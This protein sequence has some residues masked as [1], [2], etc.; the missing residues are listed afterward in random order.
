MSSPFPRSGAPID[1]FMTM[2]DKKMDN[3]SG[4]LLMEALLAISAAVIVL[5]LGAQL[6]YVSLRSSQVAGDRNIGLGLVEEGIGAVGNIATE[7][8]QNIYALTKTGTHY[9]PVV[10]TGKWTIVLGDQSVTVGTK[11]FTRY[12]TVSNVCRDTVTRNI[13]GSTDTNGSTML[14]VT[15]GGAFD[16]ST[17]L[18][19]MNV[20][21][22]DSGDMLSTGEYMLRWRNKTCA[23]TSW[24]GGAGSGVKSCPD[25][26]Y[27]SKTNITAGTDLQLT[28]Q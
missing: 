15:N 27:E 5:S 25:T 21:L 22:P 17:Q 9:Y 13:T 19:A 16:P 8:W 2:A 18:V 1:I 11:I 28:P 4:Q 6:V 7:Q 14:C 24:A 12:F 23:Q 3:R 26:T 10:A 20:Q